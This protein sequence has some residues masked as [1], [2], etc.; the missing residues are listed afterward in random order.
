MSTRICKEFQNSF[1]PAP[2]QLSLFPKPLTK[3]LSLDVLFALHFFQAETLPILRS[4]FPSELW[5]RSLLAIG[6]SVPAIMHLIMT[7]SIYHRRIL[8]MG[9]NSLQEAGYTDPTALYALKHHAE[10]AR[11]IRESLSNNNPPLLIIKLACILFTMLEFLRG[12]RADTITHL[13]SGMSLVTP[14]TR[15]PPPQLDP[16]EKEVDSTLSR[17]SLLQSLYG[18]PRKSLFPNLWIIPLTSDGTFPEPFK[19]LQE[20]RT[21]MMNLC[22]LVFTFVRKVESSA[23]PHTADILAEQKRLRLQLQQWSNAADKLTSEISDILRRRALDLLRCYQAIAEIFL[24]TV[25]TQFQTSFDQFIVKF[26]WIVET[27]QLVLQTSTVSAAGPVLFSLD[28]GIIPCLFY[29]A[30]KCRHPQ[31]RRRAVALLRKAPLRE[32][33]W[34][35]REAAIVAEKAIEFEERNMGNEDGEE[36]CCIPEE[37]RIQDIDIGEMLEDGEALLAIVFRCRPYATCGE[38]EET[39]VDVKL[40]HDGQILQRRANS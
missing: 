9:S 40:Q 32:G 31:T 25:T 22:I 33:L 27:L 39:H 8:V 3:A 15:S 21:A 12:N 16:F 10:A 29:T 2:V 34:N 4:V 30:I 1:P 13:L 20:A 37:W 26:R 14:R 38:L 19:D 5:E 35:A 11:L 17:L 28:L 6:Q 23:S 36:F 18:R 24:K 7:I